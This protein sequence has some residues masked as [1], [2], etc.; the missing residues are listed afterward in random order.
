MMGIPSLLHKLKEVK[1]NIYLILLDPIAA[2]GHFLVILVASQMM[3]LL[4]DFSYP[5]IAAGP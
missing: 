4:I 2:L 5:P 1:G 3:P